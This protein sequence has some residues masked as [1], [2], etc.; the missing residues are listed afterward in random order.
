MHCVRLLAVLRPMTLPSAKWWSSFLW[1][2]A[3]YVLFADVL[4]NL[5]LVAVNCSG[6][7][8][9]SDRPGPGWQTPH[10]PSKDEIGFFLSFA[11]LLLWPTAIYGA[12]FAAAGLVFR[13]CSLPKWLIRLIATPLAFIASGLMMAAAGWMIAISALGIYVAAGSGFIWGLLVLPQFVIRRRTPPA[14][15]IR[16]CLPV[17]ILVP[18]TSLLLRPLLPNP[19]ETQVT[20]FVIEKTPKGKH[21]SEMDWK[22]FGGMPHFENAPDDLYAPVSLSVMTMDEKRKARIL[23]MLSDDPG[24]D[25]I[26]KAPRTGDTVYREKSQKYTEIQRG[27]G[28]ASFKIKILKGG[29]VTSEGECCHSGTSQV[30]GFP[31]QE[32]T[33]QAKRN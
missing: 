7:L 14:M 31:P 23:V 8:P 25:T 4:P 1:I 15:W 33:G 11:Q 5:L 27:S 30:W 32:R 2:L 12:G 17:I 22:E 10:F 29:S 28:T 3:T 24:S 19:A 26:L 20:V 18:A 16:V 21:L 13:F 9:Y 6:Y